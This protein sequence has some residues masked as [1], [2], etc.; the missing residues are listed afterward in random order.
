MVQTHSA[1]SIKVLP[2]SVKLHEYKPVLYAVLCIQ[3]KAH[4]MHFMSLLI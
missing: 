3:L 2:A 1:K 4:G